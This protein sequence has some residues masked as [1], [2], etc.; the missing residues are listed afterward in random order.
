MNTTTL[1]VIGAGA[2]VLVAAGAGFWLLRSRPPKEEP[3][4]H[5]NC[6]HCRRKLRY[7]KKQLGHTGQCPQCRKP[8]TFPSR[9]V[10]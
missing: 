9:P 7:R 10:E 4:Y 6:P 1:L 3:V 5:F 2:V 8:L